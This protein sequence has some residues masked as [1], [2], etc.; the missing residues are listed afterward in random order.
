MNENLL[1]KNVRLVC[2][3]LAMGTWS[4]NGAAQTPVINELMASNDLAH[5]DDFFE[6]DDWVEIY[7]P[8]G[9]VQLAGVPFVRRPQQPDQIHHSRH[10]SR[11]DLLDPR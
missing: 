5:Y 2:L 4:W 8:G 1:V 3:V 7:N 9:L 10:G 11:D 6:F